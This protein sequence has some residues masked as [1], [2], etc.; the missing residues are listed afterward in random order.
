MNSSIEEE[1]CIIGIFGRLKKER[2]WS[3]R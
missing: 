2:R 1:V 3:E